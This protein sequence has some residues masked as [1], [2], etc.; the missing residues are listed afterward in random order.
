MQ[1]TNLGGME[2][3]MY[4]LISSLHKN[5]YQFEVISV[6]PKGEGANLLR[7]WNVPVYSN[8][9]RG[10]Y[11]W[12]SYNELK[13]IIKNKEYD[14]L[15][16]TG[17]TLLGNLLV[18]KIA[19]RPRVL[20]VHFHHPSKN[21]ALWWLFY[22][23]FAKDF[24]RIVYI[25]DF[26]RQEAIDIYPPLAEISTTIYG[27]IKH[28][29]RTSYDH[30][31]E[32]KKE[33]GIPEDFFVLGGCGWLIPRKRFD[34]FL[35]TVRQVTEEIENLYVVIAG[36]GPERENLE[37]LAISLGIAERVKFLG[38]LS[39]MDSFYE[40]MDVFLFNSDADALPRTPLETMG[41]GIP[42]VASSVYGG[43]N[44][45]IQNGINGFITTEHN[46]EMLS[47]Y[48]IQLIESESL[49]NKIISNAINY[50][51]EN[52]SIKKYVSSYENLF[53][54]LLDK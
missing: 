46:I 29:G 13:S 41:F 27:P 36:D 33:L 38:W 45:I 18:H 49:R 53:S 7:E 35:K 12:R 16:V 44:E 21:K 17:P 1:C 19:H 23:R 30:K 32:R 31:I 52:H 40:S 47:Q 28:I 42:V 37:R 9:Y 51:Q 48:I 25:S 10:K 39:S 26:I 11:G 14:L 5:S 50:V 24:D 22:R 6:T 34:V 4:I 15:L 20:T 43:L 2:R 54:K 8:N 3:G